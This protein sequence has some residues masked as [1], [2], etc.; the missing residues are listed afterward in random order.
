MTN[1]QILE[2]AIK[3]AT[4]KKWK[5][6]VN[7]EIIGVSDNQFTHELH[8]AHKAP[9]NNGRF[10]LG[11]SVA[12]VLLDKNFA[13]ALWGEA[14]IAFEPRKFGFVDE[15]DPDT[16]L[17]GVAYTKSLPNWQ[18]H[19]QQMVVTEDPIAYLGANI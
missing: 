18:F 14:P 15:A 8:L 3:K 2:K 19:L 7:G 16:E 13:K 10:A 12:S 6:I 4:K 1:Q 11:Q 5:P 17:E 9:W